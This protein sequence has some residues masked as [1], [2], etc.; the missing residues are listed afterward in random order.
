MAIISVGVIIGALRTLILLAA[1]MDQAVKV[2]LDIAKE[3]DKNGGSTLKDIISKID[4]TA[5]R[6]M[7]NAN[8][9][10]HAARRTEKLA[11]AIKE[12]VAHIKETQEGIKDLVK[13]SIQSPAPSVSAAI[14]APRE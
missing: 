6:A 3:F 2:L 7:E 13:I 11:Q 9:A 14:S 12:E 4:E 5:R 1:R 8:E 10:T